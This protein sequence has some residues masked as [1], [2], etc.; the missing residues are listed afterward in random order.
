MFGNNGVLKKSIQAHEE[1]ENSQIEEMMNLYKIEIE[2]END[3]D[4]L[5]N[6]LIR[7][8]LVSREDLEI[9]GIA[10]INETHIVIS[11]YNGLKE[12][13]KNVQDGNDYN[14]KKIYVVNDIDCKASF[15]SDTGEL[16]NGENFNPI[17]DSNSRIE[18]EEDET[19]IKREFNGEFDGFDYTIRNLYIKENDETE[20]CTGLFGYVGENGVVKNLVIDD[21]YINGYYETG[22]FVGRNKGKIEN[23]INKTDII[24]DY[25]LTGGIAG[26]NTGYI[27]NCTNIGN[28]NGGSAEGESSQ[29]GGIVGNCDYGENV[30]VENC[31][32]YGQVQA[33]GN[34]IGGIVGGMFS[35]NSED[36]KVTINNCQNYG[37]VNSEQNPNVRYLG[38][39]VGNASKGEIKNCVNQGI[40]SGCTMVGGIVGIKTSTT[41]EYCYNYEEIS[42]T[43]SLVGG[44]AG[45]SSGGEI[46]KCGNSG[47]IYI[48]NGGYYGAGGIAGRLGSDIEES[49]IKLCYNTGEIYSL[50]EA[51]NGRQT[52]GI[53]GN[54]D[55]K[56][57]QKKEIISCY[58]LGYVH[59]IGNIGGIVGYAKGI[60][61]QNCYN[62]GKL[63]VE[64][65][66]T[67][68]L[69]GVV[70]LLV[71]EGVINDLSNNY[72]LSDCGAIYGIGNKQTNDKAENKSSEE[73]KK[74]T[75]ILGNDYIED[76]NYI[77][78]GY[79]YIK[80]N[81][82]R[83]K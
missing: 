25:H 4:T 72:W 78:N 70:A 53:V 82:I 8:G 41:I 1:Y 69:G 81:M 55:S 27:R 71:T 33:I 12:I 10:E 30:I 18:N 54:S 48:P 22:A 36:Y 58:N 73:L 51:L 28:I 14:G 43:S 39:I 77:N 64:D 40:I 3:T 42:A 34:C 83:K 66:K 11:D 5:K 74:I 17:G 35:T 38:G 21:S 31:I 80:E 29:T 76:I 9:D 26:R 61:I 44:I 62:A 24:G 56:G 7:D 46:S 16:L 50:A 52:G 13:S 6:K 37:I 60:T 67:G 19:S 49:I 47:K 75:E 68:V 65:G 23:C 63:E 45:L 32:N 79:P 57:T 2:M 15:N 20:F 59:G